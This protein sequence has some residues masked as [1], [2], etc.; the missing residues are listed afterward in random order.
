VQ[1]G[2]FS[3][4]DS[5]IGLAE[6]LKVLFEDVTVTRHS[7]STVEIIHRVRVSRSKTLSE[8]EKVERRLTA[9]GFTDAF[10]VRL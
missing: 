7:I 6:R 9:M 4:K 3:N 5:A 10:V 1:V 2:A 8:A